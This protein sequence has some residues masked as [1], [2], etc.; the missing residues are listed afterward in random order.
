MF[1]KKLTVLDRR[2]NL[3]LNTVIDKGLGVFCY[4]DIKAGEVLE[5]TPVKLFNEADTAQLAKTV[6]MDYCFSAAILPPSHL[7]RFGIRAPE[8]ASALIMGMA[9]YCNHLS[10][11]NAKTE[12][13]TEGLTT[14]CT[15]MALK[16]IP[17]DT[18]ISISYGIAWFGSRKGRPKNAA[19]TETSQLSAD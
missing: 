12:F 1:R 4:G 11:P 6:L 3:Y 13:Q 10:V 8:Q 16:D 2:K 18:E 9:S 14:L 17:K 7:A 5:V 19:E 15:L